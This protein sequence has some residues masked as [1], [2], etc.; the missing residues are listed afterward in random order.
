MAL[1]I[2]NGYPVLLMDLGSGT[3]K[4]VNNNRTVSDNVW[5]QIIVDRFV[6][7]YANFYFPYIRT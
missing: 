7:F 1:T 5:R 4:I 3:T 6:Q 2:E